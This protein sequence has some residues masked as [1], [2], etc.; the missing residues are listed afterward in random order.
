MIS[1]VYLL[2][3]LVN[4]WLL[5]RLDLGSTESFQQMDPYG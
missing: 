3:V 2:S 1:T 4:D 5:F